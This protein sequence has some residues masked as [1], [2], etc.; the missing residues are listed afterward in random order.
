MR[1]ILIFL[2]ALT[3]HFSY[4]QDFGALDNIQL[5]N[6]AD[7]AKSKEET[8][9]AVNYIL[10]IPIDDDIQN[11]NYINRYLVKWVGGKFKKGIQINEEISKV[12]G[13]KSDLL[14][15]YF[16]SVAKAIII[17]E[18]QVHQNKEIELRSMLTFI[19]YCIN[20]YNNVLKSE[21]LKK[22]LE[23]LKSVYS[24]NEAENIAINAPNKLDD[25]GKK[26]GLWKESFPNTDFEYAI[27]NYKNNVMHGSFVAYYKNNK[28]FIRS[29][30]SNGKMD[31]D[32]FIYYPSGSLKRKS[33]IVEGKYVGKVTTFNQNGTIYTEEDYK[34]GIANGFY[35]SYYSNG[36]LFL[37]YEVVNGQMN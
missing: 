21:K 3:M 5:K 30:F 34:N 32:H 27:V 25:N 18:L 26:Q 13:F 1:Y 11:R 35:R 37:D 31:G 29:N 15:V 36:N 4:S 23:Y 6:A 9:R 14:G 19:D 22:Q 12:V 10:S 28:V 33:K 2:L 8:L 17:E 16:A 20:D 7:Y 24:P